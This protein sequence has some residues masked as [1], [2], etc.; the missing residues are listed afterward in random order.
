MKRM[1]GARIPLGA[2]ATCRNMWLAVITISSIVIISILIAH[3]VYPP[4]M[5]FVYFGVMAL[6]L[7]V[8]VSACLGLVDTARASLEATEQERRSDRDLDTGTC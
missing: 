4:L 3:I 1:S 7:I 8:S 5:I 6:I 2:E